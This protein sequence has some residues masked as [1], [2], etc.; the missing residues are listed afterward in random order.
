MSESGAP[1][2]EDALSAT[3]PYV[4]GRSGRAYN[5]SRGVKDV[6]RYLTQLHDMGATSAHV[7]IDILLDARV[8]LAAREKEATR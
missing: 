4:R 1:T 3:P 6:D 5:V 7:D 2:L 8:A